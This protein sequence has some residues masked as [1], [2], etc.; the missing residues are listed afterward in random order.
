MVFEGTRGP[1]GPKVRRLLDEKYSGEN[2]FDYTKSLTHNWE[3]HP[4]SE[5]LT[6]LPKTGIELAEIISSEFHR[7][8]DWRRYGEFWS[9]EAISKCFA[10]LLRPTPANQTKRV[11]IFDPCVGSGSDLLAV[12]E[13]W[14]EA[15]LF[16]AEINRLRSDVTNFLFTLRGHRIEITNTDSLR[17]NTLEKQTADIA[18]A[19]PPFGGRLDKDLRD[20]PQWTYGDPGS[21]ADNAWI[22]IV[23]NSLN[24]NGRAAILLPQGFC[25]RDNKATLNLRKAIIRNN[26]LD[27]VISIPP[28]TLQITSIPTVMFVL[29]K[30]RTTETRKEI[31]RDTLLML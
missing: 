3:T 9:N 6:G 29:A 2:S 4:H 27:A 10:E 28:G 26:L 22:Q 15:S 18:V 23:L 20:H 13:R 7:I 30:D 25:H 16:G 1:Q 5:I 11:L 19:F 21:S 12:S 31:W 14:P 17:E 8:I 24:Q